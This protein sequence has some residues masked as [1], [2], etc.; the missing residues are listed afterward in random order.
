MTGERAGREIEFPADGETVR[1]YLATPAGGTGPGVVVL[2]EWWGLVDHIRDVCDRFAR[3]G[4]VALAPD[5]YRGETTGDPDEAGRLMM[6]L[7]IPRAAR[8]L[9]GAVTCLL[10][11]HAVDGPRVGAIGFCMGGQLALYAATRNRRI[12]AVADFYGVHPRVTL[13]L[14]G[15]EAPVLGVFAELDEFVPPAA[16]RELEAELRE[17]GKRSDFTI[18]AGARH[19]FFNDTRPDVFAAAPA[20]RAWADTLAFFRAELR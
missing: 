20:A 17:A 11:Q 10:S 2:Q 13:D 12:G 4:F 5:L 19:A 9:D 6:D 7:E 8:D 1:G 15:L 18:H 14:A 16:A 3:E